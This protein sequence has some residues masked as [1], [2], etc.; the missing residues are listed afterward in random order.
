[1]QNAPRRSEPGTRCHS[2]WAMTHTTQPPTPHRLAEVTVGR[3]TGHVTLLPLQAPVVTVPSSCA[4]EAKQQISPAVRRLAA[5]R[6]AQVVL[7]P[8]GPWSPKPKWAAAASG[9]SRDAS[10][11][12][13]RGRS[14]SLLLHGRS[15][16]SP[17]VR[18][19]VKR[20]LDE[21]LRRR[22]GTQ[23][24]TA[25]TH[26]LSTRPSSVGSAAHP[27]IFHWGWR[28]TRRAA[29]LHT[30]QHRGPRMPRGPPGARAQRQIPGRRVSTAGHR[31]H[32]PVALRR[33]SR[34]GRPR[35]TYHRRFVP[36]ACRLCRGANST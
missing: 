23:P 7:C 27:Q 20:E 13:T 22:R 5:E 15:I 1:M 26:M 18:Q 8:S 33:P 3:C 11:C 10:F 12:S 9:P 30:R 32:V 2:L 19:R 36:R 25:A 21:H 14:L 16:G 35:A 17:L 6:P 29:Q 28:T 24:A 4:A 31:G 34:R